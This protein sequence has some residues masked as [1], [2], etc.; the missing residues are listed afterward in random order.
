MKKYL[1]IVGALFCSNSL[2]SVQTGE[3]TS[4]CTRRFEKQMQEEVGAFDK[5]QREDAKKFQEK[6]IVREC[7]TVM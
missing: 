2:L 1:L 5:Q 6:S 4:E 3:T 7:C